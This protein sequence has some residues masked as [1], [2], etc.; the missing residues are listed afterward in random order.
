MMSN[1]RLRSRSL[2]AATNPTHTE[3]V[4]WR[5]AHVGAVV[6]KRNISFAFEVSLN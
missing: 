3:I 2:R 5:R 4:A 1:H 6:T